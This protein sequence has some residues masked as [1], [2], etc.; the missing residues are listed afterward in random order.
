MS[1][2][3]KD[4]N[5]V[6]CFYIDAITNYQI[7]GDPK[8]NELKQSCHELRVHTSTIL[9]YQVQVLI[10]ITEEGACAR[11]YLHVLVLLKISFRK[12]Y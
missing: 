12:S 6:H 2:S 4:V 5:H 3:Q 10:Y 11:V 9:L 1:P 7:P 8:M